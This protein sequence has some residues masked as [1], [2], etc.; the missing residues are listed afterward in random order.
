MATVSSPVFTGVSSFANDLQSVITRAVAIASLPLNQL[1]NELQTLDARQTALTGLSDKFGAL[2]TAIQNISDS[3][4]SSSLLATSSDSTTAKVT[5]A[6]GAVPDTYT[7][8]I[9]DPG[10][11]SA[12][13]SDPLLTTVSDPTSTSF[14]SS[15]NFTLTLNGNTFSL[16]PAST[17]LSSLVTA[18]NTSGA[19]VQASLINTGNSD[20][21]SYRLVV[22]SK[23]L[24]P[25][26]IQLNDGAAD[27][28]GDLNTGKPAQYTINGLPT[29]ITSNSRTVTVAPGVTVDLLKQTVTGQPVTINV[30]RQASTIQASLSKFVDAYNASVDAL[31]AQIGSNAGALSGQ[32]VIYTLRQSLSQIT[33]I[34]QSGPL[35]S[36][37]QIGVTLDKT[38]KLSFNATQFAS[39]DITAVQS[40]LGAADVSG[41][42]QAAS[43]V[44]N[45]IE[46]PLTG[47][48]PSATQSMTAEI[49]HQ[50]SLIT[51][52]QQRV[53]DLQTSLQQQMSAAD[54]LLATL[55]N[56]KTY[57]NNLFTVMIN[58]NNQG[59]VKS[60]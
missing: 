43:Q 21:P 42:L 57:F 46:D 11:S 60:N 14:S 10:A 40:F 9:Q 16:T 7:L 22:R 56:Q 41:F 20:A 19:D 2:Q 12:S 54:A 38:G 30:A 37:E 23:S 3:M 32:S 29:T 17:S 5:V 13:I 51:V 28:L 33:Q 44:M 15:S 34:S 8:E 18:I 39:L 53:I 31:D 4:G 35:S 36:L 24:A 1:Q 25:D 52:N 58:G 47:A 26:T 6:D 55:E 48:L 50:N 49:T 59:G 45:Q 27:L